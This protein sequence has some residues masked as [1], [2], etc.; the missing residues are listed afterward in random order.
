MKLVESFFLH[1]DE[2]AILKLF[3]SKSNHKGLK[4]AEFEGLELKAW[5]ILANTCTGT[6]TG[7]QTKTANLNPF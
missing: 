6:G 2:L 7:T 3:R 4:L 1:T 5:R